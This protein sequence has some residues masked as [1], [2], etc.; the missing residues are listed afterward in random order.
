MSELGSLYFALGL[1][2]NKFN[3]AIAEAKRKVA[4]LT[5]EAVID[6]KVN[7]DKVTS[8]VAKSI[9]KLES[10]GKVE[11]N[12]E[13]SKESLRS[14]AE[15]EE[16]LRNTRLELEKLES[17]KVKNASAINDK[18]GYIGVLERQLVKAKEAEKAVEGV[19]EA[20]Q[21]VAQASSSVHH[22]F[23]EGAIEE[24]KNLTTAMSGLNAQMEVANRLRELQSEKSK[25]KG[26]VDYEREAKWVA[27]LREEYEKE[28]RGGTTADYESIS[29][30]RAQNLLKKEFEEQERIAKELEKIA[31]EE[32]KLEEK[33]EAAKRA[34]E[35]RNAAISKQISIDA[36]E[37]A[38]SIG[39]QS[40]EIK[41]L[42][43]Y[44]RNLE[45]STAS[46]A[47]KATRS[48]KAALEE[49]LRLMQRLEEAI[50]KLQQ[51]RARLDTS[52]IDINSD[53]YKDAANALDAYINKL[54]RMQSTGGDL[55]SKKVNEALG[56]DMSSV[57]AHTRN[58][59]NEQK[60]LERATRQ[61]GQSQ[62]KANKKAKK[63]ADILKNSSDWATQLHNQFS[64]FISIYAIEGFVRKLYE[65]GGEFQK[66]QIA[67]RTMIGDAGQANAIFERTKQ[68]SVKSPFT[69]SEL[70]SYTKQMSAYGIEYE[71]LYDTT[72]RLADISAGV[73]V[74]MGRLILAYGQV[75]S[76]EVLRGQEL[77]QFTEAGIP[78]VQELAKRL[79]EVR[80]ESVKVGEV[81]DA[82]SK[83]EIPFGMVQDVLFDMTDPGGKFFE[84]Q[85]E[86]AKSLAGQWSNLKDAWDIMISDIANST[87]GELTHLATVAGDLLRSWRDWA[88][89]LAAAAGAIGFVTSAIRVATVA[90]A[91]WNTVANMNPW[92][93]AAGIIMGV[94]GAIGGWILASDIAKKNTAQL[95]SELDIEI[96]KWNENRTNALR[97]IDTLKSANTSEEQRI[98]L[99]EELLEL[100]PDVFKSMSIEQAMLADTA[101]LK[102]GVNN[103]TLQE[104]MAAINKD[105]DDEMK[106]VREI[107]AGAKRETANGVKYRA[108]TDEEKAELKEAEDRIKALEKRKEEVQKGINRE[109]LIS[110]L[111]PDSSIDKYIELYGSIGK[112]V[113]VLKQGGVNGILSNPKEFTTTLEYY[114]QLNSALKEQEE[115]K[116]K[117][118]PGTA[119]Y[120][121]ANDMVTIYRRAIDAI[122][123]VWK[124][125]SGKKAAEEAAKIEI[126]AYLEAIK[127]EVSRATE[128]WSLLKELMDATGDKNLAMNI[129]FN[130]EAVSFKSELEWLKN[131]IQ[132]E[133]T[134]ANLGISLTDLLGLGEKQLLEQGVEEKVAKAIGHLIDTYNKSNKKLAADTVKEFAEIIKASRSFEEQIAE[135]DRK[136]K[137][138]LVKLATIPGYEKGSVKYEAASKELTDKANKEKINIKFEQFKE[139]SDWVK[140]F[141]DLDRVS[142]A[143]L[144]NMIVKI[145]EFAKQGKMSEEVTKQIVEA[146]AKLR[147]E[148]I[149]RN[150]FKGFED[151]WNRLKHFKE[152]KL[153]VG[154]YDEHGKLITQKDV[155]DGIAEA[156][157]DLEKS[158]LDIAGKFNAVSEAANMLSGVFKGFGG[159]LEDFGNILSG[160]ANGA[161]SGS[162]IASALGYDGPWGAIAGAVLGFLSAAFE[163]HDKAIQ[164]EIEASEARIKMINNLADNLEQRLSSAEGG[165]Y[166]IG[167]DSATKK[168]FAD[169]IEGFYG[170]QK[171][172][173]YAGHH[174]GYRKY[175]TYSYLSK[176]TIETM[177]EA[178]DNDSYY[179]AQLASLKLQRDELNKQKADL[180]DAKDPDETKIQDKLLEIEE[181]ERE[182]E[183]FAKN[184]MDTIYGIDFKDWASQ[185]TDSIVDAWSKG[186]DA[187]E[188]YKQTVSDVMRNVAASVIQQSI[189]G[190]W[191]E[192]NMDN[193]LTLFKDSGGIV[194]DE[195]F[196]ALVE[197]A[198]GVGGK[199]EETTQFLDAW[200]KAL[201]EYDMSMKDLS[202]TSSASSGLSKS[203]QGVT[204]NTADL[205]GSYLNAMRV[206]VSVKRSLV[207]Q[208]VNEAVPKIN[209]L[210]EAQLQ[211]LQ[212]V[213]ANTRRN[214]DAADKIYDLVN[215][216]VDKGGN[217][218]R[219]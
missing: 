219:V 100:Y 53:N 116:N 145:E 130:G 12:A 47:A 1:D 193:V 154:E 79:E 94:V 46:D 127:N 18:K 55:S 191:L 215:R 20:V 101:K 9:G 99:Y 196:S 151:A 190:K 178:I 165:I 159:D 64:G 37:A 203:I 207:E 10:K 167:V 186:E 187:A 194:T 209:Y 78:L 113:K 138:D 38:N 149:E 17:A 174:A 173:G 72:K 13:V 109:D 97:Y 182:L 82:I 204:E 135:I 15:L 75:R 144:D 51:L 96:Q 148:T 122:G 163:L 105:L 36:V 197:L 60:R 3:D 73:G 89:A 132:E 2:D 4:E 217:K 198:S 102:S 35:A 40:P 146:M 160:I 67:L 42:N 91:A 106:K 125:P 172:Q 52:G 168:V 129:A 50:K 169:F 49:N 184:M 158:V 44:Y 29:Y 92:V 133:A 41:A 202:D 120:K 90:S 56:Q 206:D 6:A 86:L 150:P 177:Q 39:R 212:M 71:N 95:N 84:M 76:A 14:V 195:V 180:E 80:G 63:M 54:Q 31:K 19:A 131:R 107:R 176:D 108:L 161:Q 183:S 21:E 156:N 211:Q 87:N 8:E 189:I 171:N 214:A 123:G 22:I 24:V 164:K 5:G 81:F 147:E 77:R 210:A 16:D 23:D 57:V 115:I 200:E 114:D 65:V 61:T 134:K 181:L 185:F 205:L 34:K 157:D 139:S 188:A 30:K 68:L 118:K 175:Q 98:R 7:T 33:A 179:Q 32:K 25:G 85:E 70:A 137:E 112:A 155:D 166:S 126:D 88:P 93:R 119:E 141:D 62:D 27:E 26:R 58:A 170:W 192:D 83:R 136:L 201:N 111:T 143:T 124:D 199:I 208:L 59:V 103:Q 128:K 142:N 117:F 11:I 45:R 48:N 162:G 74:D 110:K 121:N 104:Q 153:K 43:Q 152:L 66:Q 218:L 216:V 69:F 28:G 213:V 140:V